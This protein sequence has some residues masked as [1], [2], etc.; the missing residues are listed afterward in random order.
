MFDRVLKNK[1]FVLEYMVECDTR[2]NRLNREEK[3]SLRLICCTTNNLKDKIPVYTTCVFRFL[4]ENLKRRY[5]HSLR[6]LSRD[7]VTCSSIYRGL[8]KHE[9]TH[10]NRIGEYKI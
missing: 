5:K 2:I 4:K 7:C 3:L 6:L 9:K 8:K 1:H 10:S